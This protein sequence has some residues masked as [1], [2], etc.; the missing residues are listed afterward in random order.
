MCENQFEVY[1]NPIIVEYY[2]PGEEK[3][4]QVWTGRAFV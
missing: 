2:L 3:S 1:K 4:I